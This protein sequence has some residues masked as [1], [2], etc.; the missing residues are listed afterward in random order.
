MG[1]DEFVFLLIGLKWTVVLSAV[2]FV[3]GGIA[4]SASPL[5]APRAYRCWNASRPPISPSSRAHRC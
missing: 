1:H 4:G 2:G 3:C 5:R